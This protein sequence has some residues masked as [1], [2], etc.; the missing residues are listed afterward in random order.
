MT[1]VLGAQAA[2]DA[3]PAAALPA[4]RERIATLERDLAAHRVALG[5]ARTALATLAAEL[6]TVQSAQQRHH[7]EIIAKTAE[8]ARLEAEAARLRE[9]LAGETGIVAGALRTRYA[10]EREPKLKFVLSPDRLNAA[11]RQLRYVDYVL[12]AANAQIAGAE[13][14]LA[15]YSA[16][17][18]AQKTETD[19]LKLLQAA[20]ADRLA[21]IDAALAARREA[22]AALDA[23]TREEAQ[24]LAALKRGMKKL[25]SLLGRL[26]VK[27]EARAKRAADEAL[28]GDF[29]AHKGRLP[30]PTAGAATKI[31]KESAEPGGA[32]WSGV[33]IAAPAGTE[34]H[35][36]APGRVVFADEFVNLGRLII[37]DHG[38]GYMSL[39]G[40]NTAL[41]KQP[42][43]DVAAG[44]MIATAG[45]GSGQS[46]SSLYFEIRH[47]GKP[48]NPILWCK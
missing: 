31:D 4:I 1:F 43:D 35:A 27:S 21:A 46:D 10:L 3:D 16:L 23:A 39:Y 20:E 22:A 38:A 30:W 11:Q 34:V 28:A 40:R 9:D 8:L 2:D 25:E 36:V 7:Q 33:F 32:S 24:R 45:A 18:Q 15:G 6:E 29:G 14:K 19:R 41:A 5:T 42:G 26:R 13:R 47:N 44:E 12:A 37:V 17:R 48:E